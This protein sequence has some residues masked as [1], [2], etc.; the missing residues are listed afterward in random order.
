M[1][2]EAHCEDR[3]PRSLFFQWAVDVSLLHGL[4]AWLVVVSPRGET[5]S[6]YTLYV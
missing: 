5:F 6:R 3:P 1:R 2:F 4:R